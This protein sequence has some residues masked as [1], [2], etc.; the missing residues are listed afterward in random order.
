MQAQEWQWEDER[1]PFQTTGSDFRQSALL[2]QTDGWEGYQDDEVE[3]LLTRPR[4][5]KPWHVP[6]EDI[7][8]MVCETGAREGVSQSLLQH[9]R[10]RRPRDD[11]EAFAQL[12]EAYGAEPDLPDPEEAEQ[13]R[14]ELRSSLR[15][16]SS[17][18]KSRSVRFADAE[19]E[20]ALERLLRNA[21]EADAFSQLPGEQ[22]EE[23]AG[24][25]KKSWKISDEDFRAFVLSLAREEPAPA[26]PPVLAASQSEPLLRRRPGPVQTDQKINVHVYFV[27]SQDVMT[28]RVSPDLR[29]GPAQPPKGNRFTD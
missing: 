11:G 22:S 16:R 9:A 10:V 26:K 1:F 29:I 13:E 19:T 23:S 18:N 14:P 7:Q 5:P 17:V 24:S 28:L 4:E 21:K 2:Y 20:D 25:K 27:D 15:R 12:L 8:A 3:E 6:D